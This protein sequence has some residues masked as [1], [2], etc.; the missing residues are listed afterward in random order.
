MIGPENLKDIKR[1]DQT[2]TND[3]NIPGHYQ[4]DDFMIFLKFLLTLT[5]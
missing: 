3:I 2:T 1:A 4:K 5:Y